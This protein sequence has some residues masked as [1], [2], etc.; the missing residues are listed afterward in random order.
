MALSPDPFYSLSSYLNKLPLLPA[1]IVSLM[2]S[3]DPA[4]A[5]GGAIIS[6]RPYMVS[7]SAHGLTL[8]IKTPRAGYPRDALVPVTVTLRDNNDPDARVEECGGFLPTVQMSDSAD[9]PINQPPIP[10]GMTH[11]PCLDPTVP[12]PVAGGA[13][14]HWSGLV[15]LHA[16]RLRAAETIYGK[17]TG[18]GLFGGPS[19]VLQ[20][21]VLRIGTLPPVHTRATIQARPSLHATVQVPV[22]ERVYYTDRTDCSAP[23]KG[24]MLGGT[25]G[26]KPADGATIEPSSVEG[27]TGIDRWRLA[28]A[29]E[30]QAPVWVNHRIALPPLPAGR[31]ISAAPCRSNSPRGVAALTAIWHGSIYVIAANPSHTCRLTAS[32]GA[33]EAKLSRD[34]RWVLWSAP[35][36]HRH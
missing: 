15:I 8:T 33:S 10:T 36:P 34:G 21:P 25:M 11:P 18:Q 5:R 3:V 16:P 1:L 7:S 32:I 22:G 12:T 9:R 30:G 28:V 35:E 31:T 26:W 6:M 29:V 17:N 13:T 20:A 14:L 4:V 27:C 19:F 2:V 24:A 23:Y